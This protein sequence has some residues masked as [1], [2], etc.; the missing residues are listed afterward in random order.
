MK[1][2]FVLSFWILDFWNSCFFF[3]LAVKGIEKSS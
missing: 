1:I 2:S 3:V